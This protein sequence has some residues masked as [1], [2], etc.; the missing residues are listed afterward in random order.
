MPSLVNFDSL[1]IVKTKPFWNHSALKPPSY[2]KPS[3]SA[4]W[5]IFHS[6]LSPCPAWKVGSIT[7]TKAQIWSRQPTSLAQKASYQNLHEMDN[8][9]IHSG[10]WGE[11]EFLDH[12]TGRWW[13]WLCR[14]G[15]LWLCNSSAQILCWTNSSGLA[16]ELLRQRTVFVI[17]TSASRSKRARKACTME[18]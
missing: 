11:Q 1:G 8:H 13:P 12:I 3:L 7:V 10:S 5:A 18:L 9:K 16:A 6:D 4:M 2:P 17:Q 15:V 14:R